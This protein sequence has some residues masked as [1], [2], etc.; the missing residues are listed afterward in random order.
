[1]TTKERGQA[2]LPDLRDVQGLTSFWK[3]ESHSNRVLPVKLI[4]LKVGKAGSPPRFRHLTCLRPSMTTR[5][6]VGIISR[7]LA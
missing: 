5:A 6:T 2:R 7:S 4:Q 3:L 1:M